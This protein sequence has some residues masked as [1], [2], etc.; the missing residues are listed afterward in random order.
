MR[1][2][3][4]LRIR[5]L[6]CRQAELDVAIWEKFVEASALNRLVSWSST[7]HSLTDRADSMAGPGLLLFICVMQ[8]LISAGLHRFRHFDNHWDAMT[9]LERPHAS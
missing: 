1:K 8:P 6:P 7:G 5:T 9:I 2:V 3:F 4:N